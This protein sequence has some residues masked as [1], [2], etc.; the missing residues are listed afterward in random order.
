MNNVSFAVQASTP[1]MVMTSARLMAL[2]DL[3][4]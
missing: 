1:S 2:V 3:I 4:R